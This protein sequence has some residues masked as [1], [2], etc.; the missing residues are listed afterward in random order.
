ML[1]AV[2]PLER[3]FVIHAATPDKNRVVQENIDNYLWTVNGDI[4]NAD[5]F[6]KAFASTMADVGGVNID[7]GQYRQVQAHLVSQV[8][9][10]F[11]LSKT[12]R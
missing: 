7:F 12:M 3:H 9:V 4:A 2:R 6:T 8:K 11:F 5:Y 10:L 1:C